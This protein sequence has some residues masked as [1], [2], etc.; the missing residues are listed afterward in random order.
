MAGNMKLHLTSP[1]GLRLQR[2]C[3]VLHFEGELLHKGEPPPDAVFLKI[4]Q[5]T[6]RLRRMTQTPEKTRFLGRFTMRSGV[7][8]LRLCTKTNGR[9]RQ[10]WSSVVLY[11]KK[12]S[13]NPPPFVSRPTPTL[14]PP[15]PLETE[16]PKTKPRIAVV[17]HLYYPDLW[18]SLAAHVSQIEEPFDLYVTISEEHFE[19]MKPVVEKRFPNAEILPA[20]NKGRDILPFL[21]ILEKI[22]SAKYQYFCKIHSKKALHRWWADGDFWRENIL[23]DLLGEKEVTASILKKFDNNPKLGL[24]ASWNNLQ[25][26]TPASHDPNRRTVRELAARMGISGFSHYQFPG[27]GMFWARDAA[28]D[29]LRKACVRADEFPSELGQEDGTMAHAVERAFGLSAQA[30]G[31]I[32]CEADEIPLWKQK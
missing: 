22:P 32:C 28:L 6:V 27:G 31:L 9:V 7:K 17:L 5:R 26:Y 11:T 23:A 20:E 30:A 14:P 25:H 12:Q 1:D 24:L 2:A 4:G 10:H 18:D 3:G 8:L 13:E 19:A 16:T 29:P 15:R 21:H